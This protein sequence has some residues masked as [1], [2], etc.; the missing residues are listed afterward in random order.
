[1]SRSQRGFQIKRTPRRSLGTRSRLAAGY[2]IVIA[3][4]IVGY[5][6]A[7]V[8]PGKIGIQRDGLIKLLQ[9]FLQLIVGAV[10]LP[11]RFPTLM[12]PPLQT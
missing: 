6:F 12:L 3:K 4:Q 7:C 8:G 10:T 11:M 5:G 2:F 9:A 1:M